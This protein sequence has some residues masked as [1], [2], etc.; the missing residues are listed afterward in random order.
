MPALDAVQLVTNLTLRDGCR[1][2]MTGPNTFP[3]G[4]RQPVNL[5]AIRVLG[6]Q[7]T[8]SLDERDS[9]PHGRRDDRDHA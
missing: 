3:L 9:P 5:M 6:R 7:Y 1:Q 8:S 2:G 4:H